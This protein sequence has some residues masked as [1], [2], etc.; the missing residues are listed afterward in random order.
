MTD[1]FVDDA[2]VLP[3]VPQ[4]SDALL[5]LQDSGNAF[6][7]RSL[8]NRNGTA[9]EAAATQD[10]VIADTV[11]GSTTAILL[12][13]LDSRVTNTGSI[14]ALNGAG[15]SFTGGGTGTVVNQAAILAKAGIKIAASQATADRL[16]LFNAGSIIAADTAVQGGFGADK[17]VNTGTIRSTGNLPAI[18][19]GAGDDVYDG[20]TGAAFGVID[21]GAGND[22]ALGG[23]GQE[24]FRG[25]EGN[26]TIDGGGGNDIVD[27][28]GS[29]F[30]INLDLKLTTAQYMGPGQGHDVLLNIE[31]IVG[32][33]HSD[34]LVG[35]SGDNTLT[36]SLG[37]DFL[38][39]GLG[40]DL[41]DGG[42]EDGD[43]DTV[44]YSGTAGAVVNLTIQTA[45]STGGYGSD[46]LVGIENLE[47]GSG[48]DSF[49]GDNGANKLTGNGG[50]DVLTGGGGNDTLDGGSGSNTAV[51]SGASDNY[52]WTN[53]STDGNLSTTVTDN[54]GTDGVDSLKNIR[55]LKFTDKTIAL[56]N[57]APT[58]ITLSHRSVSEDLGLNSFVTALSGTDADG[59]A[60]TF[61]LAAPSD[62]FT[63]TNNTLTLKR[64]LDYESASAHTV[65]I[66]AVDAY[67]GVLEQDLTITVQNAIENNPLVRSG[68]AA[69][70]FIQ[71]ENANDKLYGL[72]GDDTLSAG[73]GNDTLFGGAGSDTF[74]GGAGRDI[75]V[76]DGRPN[77][78]TNLD[79]IKDFAPADD[80][81]HLRKSIF[82]KLARKG[83]LS[84]DAFVVGN[85][86]YDKED[87]IIYLKSEGALFYDAD[88]IGPTKAVQFAWI[89]ANL[90]LTYKD[91]YVI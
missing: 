35:S 37:N 77:I 21:L 12:N 69:A 74:Y 70:E 40:A 71:G 3:A 31:S 53:P 29:G 59:D 48:A 24:I 44:R 67:G 68:T 80:T 87:R 82:T 41:L 27:Y 91:F 25:G 26:D 78:R 85:R 32:T 30:G 54:A 20:S 52:T 83:T 28:S 33:S 65:R 90:K 2:F 9:V 14:V 42:E 5:Y 36:G 18:D 46:V 49:T 45:Q 58:A 8:L 66:K 86:V 73:N 4:A 76:F 89:G 75:F 64:A 81:I 1:Y 10:I 38:E 50:D 55:L 39:G 11:N 60:L 17:I 15:L 88:G 13:G 43:S 72:A 62:W 16:D 84:P 34:T 79:S 22:M 6:I 63:L 61:S 7:G 56:K 57:A 23:I 47:G 19:L 51:F